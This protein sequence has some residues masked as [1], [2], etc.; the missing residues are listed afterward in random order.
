MAMSQAMT[1]AETGLR[2]WLSDETILRSLPYGLY[3]AIRTW[4]REL[5][6][7]VVA[8]PAVPADQPVE[9]PE[10]VSP[11]DVRKYSKDPE[12]RL[13]IIK[14]AWVSNRPAPKARH[15]NALEVP[16]DVA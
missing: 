13:R 5:D 9:R 7:R 10:D 14:E 16:N 6:A 3:C 8:E 15:V 2:E 12:E 11:W 1:N 4:T